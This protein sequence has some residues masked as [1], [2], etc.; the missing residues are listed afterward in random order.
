MKTKPRKGLLLFILL[1]KILNHE[2]S[3][4]PNYATLITLQKLQLID[5]ELSNNLQ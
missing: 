5:F 4:K 1:I 2:N 3:L